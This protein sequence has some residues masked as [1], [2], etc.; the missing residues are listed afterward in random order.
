M[1]TSYEAAHID[2]LTL[3]ELQQHCVRCEKRRQCALDLADKFAEPGW[4]YWRDYCPNAATF[5][6]LSTFQRCSKV[7]K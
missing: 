5:S 2:P 4:Q 6:M 3:R 7:Y 1:P